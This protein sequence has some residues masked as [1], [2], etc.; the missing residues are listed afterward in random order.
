MRKHKPKSILVNDGELLG[1]DPRSLAALRIAVAILVIADLLI[2]STDLIAHYTD[3]G[4]VP[5]E[6]QIKFTAKWIFCFHLLNGTWQYQAV[7]FLCAGMLAVCMA[8]GYRTRLVTFLSWLFLTSLQN[9]NLI[10]L[11]GGDDLLRML[12][13][14]G[15]FLPW[16]D[17]FSVDSKTTEKGLKAPVIC[18]AGMAYL[19]QVFLLYLFA[20]LHKS[21]PEWVNGT[22]V[23]YALSM[24]SIA[25]PL[26][27]KVL[28]Y[29]A[30]LK[31]MTISVYFFE[32]LIPILLIL[33]VFV[34]YIR[35]G[36]FLALMLMH[37]S[38]GALMMLGLFPLICI[39]AG[40]G[41]LPGALW[42]RLGW[43]LTQETPDRASDVRILPFR[44][45]QDTLVILSLITISIW[46]VGN[47]MNNTGRFP[48][49][50]RAFTQVFRLNQYWAMFSPAPRKSDGWLVAPAALGNGETVDLITQRD[51]VNWTKPQHLNRRHKHYR[52]RKFFE[53]I[54]ES[55]YGGYLPYYLEYLKRLWN[56]S[57]APERAVV[58]AK[59]YYMQRLT[60]PPGEA[61]SREQILLYIERPEELEQPAKEKQI[62]SESVETGSKNLES[63]EEKSSG[64]DNSSQLDV[65]DGDSPPN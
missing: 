34:P 62:R 53:R 63:V 41:F 64:K 52:W 21:G 65:K 22:A 35:I 3:E 49:P 40:I 14:W 8:F 5:R 15:I 61:A 30:L 19:A 55:A 20:F 51:T 36:L 38:F 9:R 31:P 42:D 60:P 29:S 39:A 2:R 6:A 26:G 47:L 56:K 10:L 16:G 24:E 33:P 45:F 50:F 46:C 1:I 54:T 32:G 59:L 57:H 28:E 7:L 13:F 17:Y 37:L 27:T 12:V 43:K 4:L 44:P 11:Q 23:Y 18:T 25:R 58:H 48:E